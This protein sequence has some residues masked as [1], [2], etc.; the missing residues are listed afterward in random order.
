M[1]SVVRDGGPT[2]CLELNSVHSSVFL[3]GEKWFLHWVWISKGWPWNMIRH[4]ESKG[5]MDTEVHISQN[6]RGGLQGAIGAITVVSH[7]RMRVSHPR[8]TRWWW[9]KGQEEYSQQR[10]P[11]G[12]TGNRSKELSSMQFPWLAGSSGGGGWVHSCG[13]VV[14][15]AGQDEGHLCNLRRQQRNEGME[16]ALA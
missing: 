6:N 9:G 13:A 12:S 4:L 11:L 10:W 16:L 8:G 15:V 7:P 3:W 1:P 2:L 5:F 14:H